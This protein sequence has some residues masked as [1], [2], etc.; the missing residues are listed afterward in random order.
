MD[1]MDDMDGTIDMDDAKGVEKAQQ[2]GMRDEFMDCTV[3]TSF[4]A[5]PACRRLD[6]FLP[7]TLV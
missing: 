1:G 7:H 3:G 2:V 6:L 4:A 5:G